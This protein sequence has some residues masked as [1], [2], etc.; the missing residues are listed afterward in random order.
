[1]IESICPI[2]LQ[3]VERSDQNTMSED[4]SVFSPTIPHLQT[5]SYIAAAARYLS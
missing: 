5:E 3:I 2:N 4:R 1:M